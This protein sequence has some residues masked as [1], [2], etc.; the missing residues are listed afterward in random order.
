M[1]WTD[2]SD[3]T[4]VQFVALFGWRL[5]NVWAEKP[6]QNDLVKAEK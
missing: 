5:Y 6:F 2:V 1:L 3:Q 4:D